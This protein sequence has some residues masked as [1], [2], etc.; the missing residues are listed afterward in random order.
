VVVLTFLNSKTGNEKP[1]RCNN[2][3]LTGKARIS[4]QNDIYHSMLS[5]LKNK[6]DVFQMNLNK[7]NK[8]S[9]GFSL[10]EL[11]IVV[12]VMLILGA[13][14]V[15]AFSNVTANAARAADRAAAVTLAS[16]LNTFNGLI[17]DPDAVAPIVGD[18]ANTD[19]VAAIAA[20]LDEGVFSGTIP[21]VAGALPTTQ[22]ATI[23]ET[24]QD[25]ILAWIEWV[26]PDPTITGVWRVMNEPRDLP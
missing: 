17:V 22:S 15:I 24:R 19:S 14:A 25:E 10:V 11:M 3:L 8:K 16:T 12:T 7:K 23:D 4:N 1:K 2:L 26:Q 13:G 6:G 5:Y 9:K 18:P 21:A 20:E